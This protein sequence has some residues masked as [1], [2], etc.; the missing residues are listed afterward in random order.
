LPDRHAQKLHDPDGIAPFQQLRRWRGGL[1]ILARSRDVPSA[2]F[3]HLA[4]VSVHGVLWHGLLLRTE[5]GQSRLEVL[6]GELGDQKG[7]LIK[8]QLAFSTYVE[9]DKEW[10]SQEMIEARK[11]VHAPGS[12]EWNLS[13]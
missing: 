13:R 2:K 9:L 4:G 12:E 7:Y 6:A 1:D 5:L 3:L 11:T 10:N 8:K